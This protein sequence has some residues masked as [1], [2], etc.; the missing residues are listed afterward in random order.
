MRPLIRM[1]AGRCPHAKCQLG[2]FPRLGSWRRPYLRRIS[3]ST[4]TDTADSRLRPSPLCLKL[5]NYET[6]YST[7]RNRRTPQGRVPGTQKF[8]NFAN[9]VPGTR[10]K[11]VAYP[12]SWGV[13]FSRPPRAC[14]NFAYRVRD[15]FF[16]RGGTRK[17]IFRVPLK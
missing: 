14:E 8:F 3:V 11:K 6:T 2:T 1:A 4:G 13:R 12:S 16:V 9:F 17:N 10:K 5:G 15:F 7:F